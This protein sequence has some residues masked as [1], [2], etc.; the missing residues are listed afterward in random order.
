MKTSAASALFAAVLA[1]C[2][3][4]G[5]GISGDASIDGQPDGVADAEAGPEVVADADGDVDAEA[6]GV[7]DTDAAPDAD[8]TWEDH[9][10]HVFPTD[11]VVDLRLDFADG[12]WEKLLLLWQ[13]TKEKKVYPAAF[14]FDTES[15]ATVGVRLKGLNSLN[16]PPSGPINLAGKYPLKIDFNKVGGPRFHEVD[17][18]A[19]NTSGND[20]SR[21]RDRLTA[22]M[23]GAMG[24]EASR[25]SWADVRI[26]GVH[27]GLYV[28]AQVI[29]KRFLKERFGEADHADDGNLYK[30]VYNSFGAC[31]LAWQG[32][33]PASYVSKEGCADGYDRC[34]L[35]LQT[36]EDDPTQNTYADLIHL[37]DVLNNTPAEQFEA[38][39]AKVFDVPHFLRLAAVA[40]ATS[41]FDSYFG[42]GH[43]YYLYHRSD[44]LFQMIPWDFDLAFGNTECP[45]DPSD[46]TCGGAESHPLTRK[47]MAVAAWREAYLGE[48]KTLLDTAFTEAQVSAW[49]SE[50]D[51]LIAPFVAGDPNLP[52]E[53]SYA[54]Q[55]DP[56]AAGVGN[57][58]RFLEARRAFILAGLGE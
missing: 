56:K 28:T 12:D 27:V 39:L 43:N 19:L 44:G 41:N 16:V 21:M 38:E 23:Y 47:I 37:L 36:N 10:D 42:K 1:A 58:F 54:E 8:P 2:A 7:A 9:F 55:I 20:A 22:S 26:D 33:D 17:E 6:D 48:L 13:T 51:A 25:T 46:P 32:A 57:L 11:H 3:G 52:G 50:A 45:T 34:G 24:V 18:V 40:Y 15:L 49:V 5:G 53:G 30:C 31:S 4:G 29:D 14:T 35:V